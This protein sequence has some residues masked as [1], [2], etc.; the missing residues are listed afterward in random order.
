MEKKEK[1]KST[2][3]NICLYTVIVLFII[4][5]FI[6]FVIALNNIGLIKFDALPT[7]KKAELTYTETNN[8]QKEGIYITDVSEIV[9]EVMPS[10]VSIT[11]KT[12]VSSGNFGPSFFNG[13]SYATGAGSGIIVSKSDICVPDTA[14]DQEYKWTLVQGG[15]YRCEPRKP[16]SVRFSEYKDNLS[17]IYKIWH[18]GLAIHGGIIAGLIT[19]LVYCKK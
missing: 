12:L 15:A 10:I 14:K 3:K 19:I 6:A 4:A 1:K 9:E 18:G 11:S 17:E 5:I 8:K 13:S 16:R 2:T 7:R